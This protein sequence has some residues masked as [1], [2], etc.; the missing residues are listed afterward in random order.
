MPAHFDGNAHPVGGAAAAVAVRRE[1]S[2]DEAAPADEL[3]EAVKDELGAAVM[4]VKGL[5]APAAR[6]AD[7]LDP[8]ADEDAV[9]SEVWQHE[10][11]GRGG[12]H[13]TFGCG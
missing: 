10:S 7:E 3:D 5:F 13:G 4:Q 8:E 1:D 9:K 11:D 6:A 2:L 12:V